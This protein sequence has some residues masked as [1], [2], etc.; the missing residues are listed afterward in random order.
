MSEY[1]ACHCRNLKA[2]IDSIHSS[3]MSDAWENM[4]QSQNCK[5]DWCDK[6]TIHQQCSILTRK[7][8][9]SNAA[10]WQENDPPAMQHIDKKTIHQQCSIL[11]EASLW[12]KLTEALLWCKLLG[13]SCKCKCIWMCKVRSSSCR[14]AL[15]PNGTVVH[16]VSSKNRLARRNT[17]TDDVCKSYFTGN[18]I[19]RLCHRFTP[20][21]IQQDNM[22]CELCLC[23]LCCSHHIRLKSHLYVC[24]SVTSMMTLCEAT[25]LIKLMSEI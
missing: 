22:W 14:G 25:T 21:H 7:R 20:I 2:L 11:T 19:Y 6:K 17:K 16:Q 10:Y 4:L 18:R 12:C 8:S 24:H 1:D 15:D 5:V 9:T 3:I 13:E 23:W